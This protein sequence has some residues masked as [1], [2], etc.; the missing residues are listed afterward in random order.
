MQ[1]YLK[2]L[3]L[4]GA[5]AGCTIETVDKSDTGGAPSTGGAKATGGAN[6]ATG[7]RTTTGGATGSSVG[8]ATG[9]SI[10]GSAVVGGASSSGGTTAAGGGAS[11]TA[12]T[13]AVGGSTTALTNTTSQ[14]GGAT[15]TGGASVGGSTVATSGGSSTVGGTS[16]TGVGGT[17]AVGTTQPD[18]GANLP[19]IKLDL[20]ACAVVA[21]ITWTRGIYD[22]TS[23]DAVTV[24]STLTIEAGSIV[25]FA[26]ETYLDVFETGTLKAIGTEEEPIIFTS[27]H[28]DAHGGDTAGDGA[29]S[30]AKGDW[31]VDAAFGALDLNGSG[32]QLDHVEV[33]YGLTGVGVHAA[34]AKIT[35]STVAHSAGI[36]VLVGGLNV[37]G[38]TLT[39]NTFFDNG[40][41]PI[42]LGEFISLDAS[43][44]FHDPGD[45]T[46]KNT[47]QCI[48]L[49]ATPSVTGTVT[50]GVTELAFYG[51]FAI[52]STLTV[53][54]GVTFKPE[55]DGEIDL[56]EAGT[57]VNGSNAI[58]TSAKDDSVGGDC[59]GDGATS[60][61]D[62]DWAGIWITTSADMDWAA[63]T[64]NIR[65]TD[66]V[67][68]PGKLPLH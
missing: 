50:L 29:T 11:T 61:A 26:P 14:F 13:S 56:N 66:Q 40:S 33:L 2:Y 59:T 20:A 39:G 35:N 51:S 53:A 52:D 42:S 63:P 60:P 54:N 32:S 46:V 21:P 8:G 65:F 6:T 15:A 37:G 17:T 30:P 12:G 5:I 57:I 38:T 58:F 47:K 48:E 3:L 23:C 28:D 34:D 22:A 44:V 45:P 62:A 64:E 31:G 68:N 7:G 18:G 55:V 19:V 10:G 4:T 1:K 43:N 27:I 41:Y 25:K 24:L 16:A 67:Q 49:A 36:G 9:T